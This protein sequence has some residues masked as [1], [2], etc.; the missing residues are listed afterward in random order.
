ME[1]LLLITI[2][3]VAA[4]F[5]ILAYVIVRNERDKEEFKHYMND[6]PEMHYRHTHGHSA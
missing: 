3:F 2:V 1:N 4:M 5:A 6:H